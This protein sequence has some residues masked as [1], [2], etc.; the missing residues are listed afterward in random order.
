M[1]SRFG[2][3]GRLANRPGWESG[4][5]IVP[6]PIIL[7]KAATGYSEKKKKRNWLV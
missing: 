6:V 3:M 4:P 7:A 5:R 2:Q 1:L